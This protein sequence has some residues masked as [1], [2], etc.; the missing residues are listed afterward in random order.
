MVLV[1]EFTLV[2]VAVPLTTLQ[3]PVV[4]ATAALAAMVKVVLLH[5]M[6]SGPAFA[7]FGL[8]W[9]VIIT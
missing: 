7:V 5:W 8:I 4:P 6:I 2:I 3:V 1:G 9:L